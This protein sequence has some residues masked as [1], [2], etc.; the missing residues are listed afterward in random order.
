MK[1]G[2]KIRKAKANILLF[3]RKYFSRKIYNFIIYQK[4]KGLE[5][6]YFT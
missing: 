3:F 6:K 2:R 5:K 4:I 1:L